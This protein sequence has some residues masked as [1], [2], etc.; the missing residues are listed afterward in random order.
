MKI[1]FT[2]GGTGGHIMPIIAVIRELKKLH[3]KE[4]FFGY[5]ENEKKL[6][7]F[8]IG[9][10]DDFSL[11]IF[12]QEGIKVKTVL[13]GKIR[14]YWGIKPFFENV[15]DLFKLPIGIIQGFFYVFF[16]APDLIFSKGGYGSIPAVIAGWILRIPVLLHESDVIPGM[17]N[18]LLSKF[19]LRIF[20]SFPKTKKIPTSKII[21]VGN[22]IREGLLSEEKTEVKSFFRIESEKPVILVLGGSQGSQRI[23][24]KI[25]EILP[26]LL[27]NFELIFQCGT[28]NLRQVK[29]ESNA[30][31]KDEL[32]KFFHLFSFLKEDEIKKAYAACDMILSRA[33]ST[34]IFEIAAAGKPSILIPLPESAQN[35]QVENAYSYSKTEAAIVLEESNIT[36]HFLL[37]KMKYLLE[38]PEEMKIMSE[39]AIKFSKPQ[40]AK[41]IAKYILASCLRK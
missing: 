6:E 22:P 27:K 16:M 35:H 15:I 2:G 29:G 5:P 19:A 40:A 41:E 33:G 38:N 18:L 12:S 24:N 30:V 1:L 7:I 28:E 9:P 10:K 20:T 8:F 34:T 13:A 17:T 14:R 21:L 11:I 4:F 23:N 39:N 37:G 25:L 26:E 32:K 31:I 3:Q 36:A